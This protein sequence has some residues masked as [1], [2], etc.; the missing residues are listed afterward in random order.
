MMQ[1]LTTGESPASDRE[2]AAS[3]P[4]RGQLEQGL[5]RAL[6]AG[7]SAVPQ[8]IRY[9]LA[10][11]QMADSKPATAA[12]SEKSATVS[13]A[14]LAAL[15]DL[16]H[17]LSRNQHKALL[18]DFRQVEDERLRL[19][20]LL[21]LAAHLP[22]NERSPLLYETWKQTRSVTD[23]FT[24]SAVL[25][26]LAPLLP[27][28][29]QVDTADSSPRGKVIALAKMM[30]NV[31]ARVRSLVAVA[32][33]APPEVS[34][35]LFNFILDEIDSVD[36]DNLHANTIITIAG[37]VSPEV[38]ARVL[39]STRAI[40]SP[41]ERARALTALARATSSAMEASIR[42]EALKAIA[43]IRSE[44]ERAEALVAFA[45]FLESASENE[46]FPALLE[47]ALSIAVGLSRRHVRARALVA[48]APH[49]TPDLQR[50]ALAAV[51]HLGNERERALL[52][53][54]LAPTLPSNMLV[55]SMMVA[56]TMQEQD[57]RVHAL[58]VLA[59]HAPEQTRDQAL[60]DALAA[61]NNLPHHYE[62]VM[63]LAALVDI[64]PP[65]LSNQAFTNAL[66]T[67]RLIE[68]EN[69]R[70][71]ALSLL[72]QHL[73]PSLLDRAL[74]AVYQIDDTQLRL[75]AL[76]GI[77]P[78]LRDEQRLAAQAHLLES[79]QQ[80]SFDYKRARAL[81]SIAPHLNP[82]QLQDA[83]GIAVDLDD[84]YDRV[85]AYIPLAQNMP[86]E[87]R[88]EII[89]QAWEAIRDIDDGYDRSSALAAIAPFLMA[90]DASRLP[91]EASRIITS[92]GDEYDR[93]SAISILAPLLS[94]EEYDD[95]SPLPAFSTVVQD[96]LRAA[97]DVP[98]QS[99]R[100]RQVIEGSALCFSLD[101]QAAYALWR[102]V[103]G[104]MTTLPLADVL[105][106]LGALSP[107][108]ELLG[109]EEALK[110][111]AH[112]LGVR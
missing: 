85:T 28:S 96:G 97:L 62:R 32:T 71:R 23:P 98:Q 25:F 92:I 14:R 43:D 72:A 112:I 83:I 34:A 19:P 81:I 44:D 52:W 42:S 41:V 11:S 91:Q 73:P 13:G 93:A 56:H 5:N 22:L 106:C 49:L 86:P 20:R 108:F 90:E 12:R 68:N 63:A 101:E 110:E 88:P 89:S 111:I 84:A 61:A 27:Q 53:A 30:D 65:Q 50:E 76:I 29:D 40:L 8:Q 99:L 94:S 67:T 100:L 15:V 95:H 37:H 10:L 77:I 87:M 54:Q 51:N 2:K 39:R 38:E 9:I 64:L 102:E 18:R 70:S 16:A 7:P 46:A 60:L 26:Q 35:N 103:A 79:T 82:E 107:L 1:P 80:I 47:Q 109:G 6:A 59:H 104:R 24:R 55:A 4:R 74:E 45:P 75:N 69:A 17:V 58:T 21:Q 36:N 3:T 33:H 105:L 31:E 57:A 48:L 66:E 78:R